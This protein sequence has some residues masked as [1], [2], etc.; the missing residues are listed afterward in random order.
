MFD[1][2]ES[3]LAICQKEDKP[4]WQVMLEQEVKQNQ[5][6]EE[7]VLKDFTTKLHV[8]SESV[9]RGKKG[10][11]SY[12]G[13]T[14]GGAHKLQKYL[15][16][17][18]SIC[19]DV[20]VQ[21]LLSAVAINEV[22]ASMGIICATP[23]AGS[24]GVVPAVLMAT[25][26]SLGLSEMDQV[27]YLITAAT[28]GMIIGNIA[29]I[30]GAEGGCQAEVGS[31]SGM[32]AAALTWAAGGTPEQSAHALSMALMNI[33]GL[34]CDPVAGL[35]EIPCIKRNAMGASNALASA[36]MALAGLTSE[37]PADEVISAMG[38]V[39]RAL[40]SA[41]RETAQGGLAQTKTGRRLARLLSSQ[42]A[43]W[44]DMGNGQKETNQEDNEAERVEGSFE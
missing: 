26:D 28:F 27:R 15:E 16:S 14:G 11:R 34:V 44:M 1:S 10:V 7:E 23:T 8:M 43:V 41:L 17:G 3:L 18:K 22:N 30:S 20:F 19:G 25:R 6:T 4:I 42:K 12:S 31:A 39:G 38:E 9:E 24:A 29:S 37:I 40:P 21:A 2:V 13:L 33:L 5:R 36:E 35:V 32:A